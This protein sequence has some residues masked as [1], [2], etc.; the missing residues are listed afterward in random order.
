[1]EVWKDIKGYEGIYQVSNYSRVRS[2]RKGTDRIMA[3]TSGTW[4]YLVVNID[5]TPKL[6]HRLVA[7]AF[8]PNPENKIEVNHINGDKFDNLISNLEWATPSENIRHAIATGL[9]K[10]TADKMRKVRQFDREGRFIAEYPSI[11]EA[12]RIVSGREGQ[13]TN[14]RK[15]CEGKRK[16]FQ[17]YYWTYV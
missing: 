10:Y 8:I 15:V 4:G 13:H 11:N 12:A 5:K 14:L 1:M 9:N 2:F 6:V 16:S 7:E 3:Q 17:G